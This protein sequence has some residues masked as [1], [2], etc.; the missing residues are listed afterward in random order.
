[1][2]MQTPIYPEIYCYNEVIYSTQVTNQFESHSISLWIMEG[3]LLELL[4]LLLEE[5]NLLLV[6]R[7]C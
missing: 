7:A 4:R 6:N 5:L 1:M 3:P 2:P